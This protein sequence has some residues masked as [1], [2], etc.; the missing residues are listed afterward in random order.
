[1]V[2]KLGY[3][4]EKAMINSYKNETHTPENQQ[5]TMPTTVQTMSYLSDYKTRFFPFY[6]RSEIGDHLIF[7][8]K[9]NYK[10][11]TPFNNLCVTVL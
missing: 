11:Q 10:K 4:S 7:T 8:D 3:T 5:D 2:E 9:E 6:S 1:M